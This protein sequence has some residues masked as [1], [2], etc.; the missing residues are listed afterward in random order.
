MSAAFAL[1]G[2][3]RKP[4]GIHG[5]LVVEPIS[6]SPA[7]VF[8]PGKRVFV[9]R[10]AAIPAGATP[11]PVEVTHGRPF[12]QAWLVAVRGVDDRNAAELWRNRFLF[13]PFD[14]LEQPADGELWV[15]ELIGMHVRD[16][17][18]AEIGTVS[19][20]T[21]VPQGILIDVATERGVV[22]IPFV[23]PIVVATDRA[24]RTITVNPPA[25]L[26][27]L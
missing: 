25:G 23:E 15:H 5:E 9:A 22:S 7:V 17:H 3:I 26:L 12:K 14:E 6:D 10:D 4:H 1:V 13:V 11:D 8:A 19:G 16:V 18:G 2:R 20:M 27:E 21:P 24:A